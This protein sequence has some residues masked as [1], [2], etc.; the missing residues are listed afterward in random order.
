MTDAKTMSTHSWVLIGPSRHT[1]HYRCTVCNAEGI[2]NKGDVSPLY[3][4]NPYYRG[5]TCNEVIIQSIMQ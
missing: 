3:Y 2:A 4:D 5:L 1:T